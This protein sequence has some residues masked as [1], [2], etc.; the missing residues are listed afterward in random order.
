MAYVNVV[1][2]PG[3]EKI[4]IEA[5]KLKVPD[6]PI[7][8]FVEG[9]GTGRDIW[10]ASVR[11][12]DAAIKKAYGDK[13]KVH[14]MEVYA[15]E[16]SFRQF[17]S[18]LPDETVQAFKEFLVGIKGPLTTP[19]GGGIRSLNVALLISQLL[20]GRVRARV[21]APDA[22]AVL[23]DIGAVK[24][25]MTKGD[26]G[27]WIGDSNPQDEGFHYYQLVI[28]GAQV[29]DP[30]SLYFYGASRWGSG[31]EVPA[32]DQDFYALEERPARP[33]PRASLLLQEQ[34]R[35]AS[36]LR[37]HAARVRRGP[38][39]AL[40]RALPPARR[41]RGRDRLAQPGQDQPDHGQPDRR[42]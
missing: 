1:V 21:V 22:H 23:L 13:R 10:R 41:R 12:F 16:K 5:G 7:I 32:K 30:G 24:Y 37:V 29:P 42:G 3:G 17:N 27:A 28:D 36:L 31:V 33:D 11:V 18:W 19:I 9:D 4:T 40:S 39:Q 34:Q 38:D 20:E 2:P 14:W 26:D 15:G 6:Q 8:P 35:H 25:P